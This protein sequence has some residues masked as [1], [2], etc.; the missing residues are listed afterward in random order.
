M[1]TI[2]AANSVLSLSV[3]GLFPTAQRIQGFMA[4]RAFEQAAVD[5]AQVVMGVDGNLSAGFTP[6]PVEMTIAIMPDSPSQAFFETLINAMVSTREVLR[7]DGSIIL[8]SVNRVYTLT[9]GYLT[10]G[11]IMPDVQKVLQGTPFQITWQLVTSA[12]T[13]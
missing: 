12:Q 2:T 5:L 9:K 11:K 1:S 4:D 13:A 6:N 10:Q 8:P 7:L 3:A